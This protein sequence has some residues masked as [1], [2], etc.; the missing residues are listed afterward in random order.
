MYSIG[1]L[2]R[3]FNLSRSTLLYYD[4]IGLLTAPERNGVNYRQYSEEDKKRLS[5]ICAFREAGVP[6]NQIKDILDTDGKNE[7]N[8]L[9]KRLNE[10]NHEIR[11]LRLQQKLIVEMLKTKNQTDKKLPLDS[12]TFVSVLKSTGFDEEILNYFHVQ[13][14]KNS[15]DFHQLFLEFLGVADEEIKYIREFS[16]QEKK[17]SI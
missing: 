1:K 12:R 11:C 5:Q 6:L 7:S 2:C 4:T 13:F 15:P 16:R 9:E 10:L 14:E 3:A 8:I 17:M